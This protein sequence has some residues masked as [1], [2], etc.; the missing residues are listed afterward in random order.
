MTLPLD[1]IVIKSAVS[2]ME[3]L[4]MLYSIPLVDV[5]PRPYFT[6]LVSAVP[7]YSSVQIRE[8]KLSLLL[9]ISTS[10]DPELQHAVALFICC[11][12]N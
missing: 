8:A 5:P 10:G 4:A 9:C 12:R 6:I 2:K 1:T 11:Q 3:N 7:V